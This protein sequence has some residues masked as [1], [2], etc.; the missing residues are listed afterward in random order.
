MGRAKNQSGSG[1]EIKLLKVAYLGRR[2]NVQGRA[3]PTNSSQCTGLSAFSVH[4]GCL[5]DG[6]GVLNVTSAMK[7]RDMKFVSL[8]V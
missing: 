4:A 8:V 2:V 3:R 1:L 7:C 6:A 5:P